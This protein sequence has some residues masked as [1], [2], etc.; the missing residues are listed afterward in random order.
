[1]KCLQTYW[2]KIIGILFVAAILV[3]AYWYGGNTPDSKGF[4]TNSDAVSQ[5]EDI[6]G[7]NLKTENTER[8]A[9]GKG[10][11]AFDG[12]P[13]EKDPS[14]PA[15]TEETSAEESK[16][17]PSVSSEN[18]QPDEKKVSGEETSE[19]ENPEKDQ[20]SPAGQKDPV[21]SSGNTDTSSGKQHPETVTTQASADIPE[22]EPADKTAGQ[23]EVYTCTVSIYCSTI[24]DNM[25]LLDPAKA[26]C[27]PSDGCILGTTTVEFT[28]G[29]TVYDVLQKVTA[30]YGIQMESS[31]TPIYGSSYIEG[32]NNLYEFDCGE[33]SGWMYS[34]NGSFPGF[35]SS[36]YVLNDKDVIKWVYTCDLG[37]DV[38]NPY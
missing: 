24:L 11:T 18:K 5:T 29:Q 2:K 33:L 19:G 38:G 14:D 32:I 9:S 31:Y 22:E 21:S 7:T 6:S 20:I 25:D 12:N 30:D 37:A 26:S 13:S 17:E 28:P 1:M 23:P 35:G 8:D 27:V 34:V 3:F 16:D 4:D 10:Q 15:G 36:Q